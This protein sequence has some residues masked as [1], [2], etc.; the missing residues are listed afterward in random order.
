LLAQP[1]RG[2][3]ALVTDVNLPGMLD[4]WEIA[5]IARE[6]DPRFPIVYITGAAAD[7]W[8]LEGRPQQHPS[9]QA[10][11]AGADRHRGFAASQYRL[12]VSVRP[13]AAG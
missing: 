5:R 7:D 2:L 3:R 11:R 8:P 4:G 12:A 1:I 6:I 13:S 9:E 10:V